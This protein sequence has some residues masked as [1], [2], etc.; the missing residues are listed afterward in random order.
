M[1]KKNLRIKVIAFGTLFSHLLLVQLLISGDITYK[2][3]GASCQY[4][5]KIIVNHSHNWSNPNQIR[6][7]IKDDN[8]LIFS[9]KNDFSYISLTNEATAIMEWKIPSPALNKIFISENSEYIICLSKIK[10]YNPY[11]LVVLKRSG[12]VIFRMH[13]TAIEAKLSHKEYD[14]FKKLYNAQNYFLQANYRITTV[15]D[16]IFID[17]TGENISVNLGKSCLEYLT[18][19]SAKSHFSP[20]FSEPDANWVYWYQAPNPQ[21]KLIFSGDQLEK[22][23]LCDPKGYRF[24]IMILASNGDLAQKSIS[25]IPPIS[26]DYDVKLECINCRDTFFSNEKISFKVMNKGEELA[27][28]FG[29]KVKREGE[30]RVLTFTANDTHAKK[31]WLFKKNETKVIIWDKNVVITRNMMELGTIDSRLLYRYIYYDISQGGEF[32]LYAWKQNPLSKELFRH[33]FRITKKL[34]HK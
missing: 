17:F 27:I 31:D 18:R 25:Y 23:S 2:Q 28:M 20:N 13:I 33:E 19:H 21:M 4:N 24:E 34:G 26:P 7:L 30:W 5:D 8:D 12:E 14:E 16:F 32:A 15:S 11:Q 22:I 29:I 6:K 3:H 10:Y 1:T 9:E